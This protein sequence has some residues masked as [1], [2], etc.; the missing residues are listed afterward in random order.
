[1]QARNANNFARLVLAWFIHSLACYKFEVQVFQ[2]EQ[3]THN[4]PRECVWKHS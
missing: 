1:M 2:F 3:R 4:L